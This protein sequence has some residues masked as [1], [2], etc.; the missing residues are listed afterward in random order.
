MTGLRLRVVKLD[1]KY[2]AGSEHPYALQLSNDGLNWWTVARWN[3]FDSAKAQA[4]SL[5]SFITQ[6]RLVKPT[7]VLWAAKHL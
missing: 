1:E 2:G 6:N 5:E 3:D 7:H 4:E